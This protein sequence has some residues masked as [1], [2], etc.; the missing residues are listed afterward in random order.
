MDEGRQYRTWGARIAIRSHGKNSHGQKVQ[1]INAV[2]SF[3]SAAYRSD[4]YVVVVNC[5]YDTI[6]TLLNRGG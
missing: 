1:V 3:D 5:G 6:G 4:G 2:L